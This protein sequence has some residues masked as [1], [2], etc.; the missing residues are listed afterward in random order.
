MRMRRI[1]L[2]VVAVVCLLSVSSCELYMSD[3]GDLDGNWHLIGIDTLATGGHCDMSERLVFWG[4]ETNL[5]EAVDHENDPR[6]YGYIFYFERVDDHLRV[7]NAHKH[8]RPQGD[9]KVQ[10]ASEIAF[11]GINSLD[12][13]FQ[14]LSLDADRMILADTDL[15]L[16]FRKQ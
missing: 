14:I 10:D 15:R 5:I 6:H 13:D 4:I 11:L 2:Y 12:D 9:I 7:F 8:D 1:L 16:V 3:N